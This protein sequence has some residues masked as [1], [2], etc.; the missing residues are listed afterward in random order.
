METQQNCGNILRKISLDELPQFLNVLKG[1][2]SIVGPRPW[3]PEYYENFNNIQKQ[4]AEVRPG[5]IGLA[6]VNGRKSI[7]V[8]KKINYDINYIKN[9]NLI[10]DLKIV[11]KSIKTIISIEECKNP[12]E[13]VSNEIALLKKSNSNL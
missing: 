6:Q 12:D 11:I 5:I 13:Y 1:D 3:I 10:L 4:R 7:N 2:M 9:V 8:L